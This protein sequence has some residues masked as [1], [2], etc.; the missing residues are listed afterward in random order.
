VQYVHLVMELC[1]G[2]FHRIKDRGRF[3]EGDAR[4]VCRALVEALLHC[5]SNGIIHR[6]VKPENI[7]MC[8]AAS[9]TR[10]KLIDF[11]V[12]TFY[13]RGTVLHP[14]TV[15]YSIVLGCIVVGYCWSCWD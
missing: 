4:A 11:G 7:L 6:D 2:L 12:A 14:C 3:P 5:H 1:G 15:L 13:K 8:T 10:I 9:H